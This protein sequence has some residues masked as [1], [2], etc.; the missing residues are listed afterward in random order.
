MLW[1]VAHFHSV[2]SLC[3]QKI[4]IPL[5]N[6]VFERSM[7]SFNILFE[8]GTLFVGHSFKWHIVGHSFKWH[9]VG[10]SFQYHFV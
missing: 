2:L 1:L 7:N 4:D 9:I 3:H 10:H 6:I 8:S 5:V